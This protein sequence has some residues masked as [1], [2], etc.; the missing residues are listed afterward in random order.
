MNTAA[1]CAAIKEG[2]DL[3]YGKFYEFLKQNGVKEIESMN[4]DFNVD[5]HE[6]VAK[7]LVEEEDKK[8]KIVEVIL[9]GYYLHDKVIRH[10]KVVIGE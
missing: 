7:T 2:L 3:I 1:D 8:G 6:A 10:S 9:K 4:C 5:L